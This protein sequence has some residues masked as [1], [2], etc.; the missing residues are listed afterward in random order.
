[1]ERLDLESS[2]LGVINPSWED[3]TDC[4]HVFNA[5]I[6]SLVHVLIPGN[7]PSFFLPS[8]PALYRYS[9]APVENG[10]GAQLHNPE[11]SWTGREFELL[12]AFALMD[13]LEA[14][15]HVSP[16]CMVSLY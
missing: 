3:V 9:M 13:K 10:L 16:G 2:T 4:C 14:I 8:C 5:I 6:P 12:Q 7:P 1:M 15:T 11:V